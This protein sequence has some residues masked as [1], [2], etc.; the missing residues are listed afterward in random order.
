MARFCTLVSRAVDSVVDITLIGAERID[1]DR[2]PGVF[3]ANH[4]SL[5]DL[6]IGLTV[7]HRLGIYPGILF[8]RRYLPGPLAPFASGAGVIL[9]EGGGAVD[10]GT[11]ALRTGRSLMVMPE[12]RLYFDPSAPNEPGTFR[13]GLA[14]MAH[15]AKTPIVP[16]AVAGTEVAWPPG[17]GPK[18]SRQPK[19]S[20]TVAVGD[21]VMTEG[22]PESDAGRVRHSIATMLADIATSR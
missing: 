1:R 5:A 19:R 20:V 11:A 3:A 10:A 2:L 4:R 13:S 15:Q 7:F 8:N 17:R 14:V 22:D 21:A 6:W 9:V 16:I 12:G 18:L